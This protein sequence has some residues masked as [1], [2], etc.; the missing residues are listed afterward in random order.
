MD[1]H[2]EFVNYGERLGPVPGRLVLDVGMAMVPGVLDH[3]QPNAEAECAASLVVRHPDFVLDHVAR[4]PEGPLTFV[5]HKLPDFD[6]LSAIFL[7]QRLIETGV[8]DEA[9]LK[10]AAY[11]RAVDSAALPRSIELAATPYAVL[12]AMFSGSKESEAQINVDRVHE[13]LRFMRHLHARAAEGRDIV[14][15]RRLFDGL[16]RYEKAARKVEGDHAQYLDDIRRGRKIVLDLPLSS[17]QGTKR[18]DGLVAVQPR[19]FLLK[20][21]ARREREEAPLGRGFGFV[22]TDYGQARFVLGVDPEAGIDLRGLAPLLDDRERR[23]RAAAGR[24]DG[25]LWYDGNCPLFRYRIIA[26]PP[27]ATALTLA[28]VIETV[29]RFSASAREAGN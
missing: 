12:R 5:T 15:D 28:D 18:V 8:V 4:T 21:W 10:L 17:G 27:D 26:S 25:L 13:G 22:L 1:F 14:E 24:A 3:H 6:G 11:A 23:A 9:M 29:L 19:S 16:E 20:E 7:A 2:Y